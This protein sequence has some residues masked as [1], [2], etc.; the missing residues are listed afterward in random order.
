[1]RRKFNKIGGYIAGA[2]VVLG[3]GAISFFVGMNLAKTKIAAT[4]A[5]YKTL[6][7]PIAV[8][9]MKTLSPI[10]TSSPTPSIPTKQVLNTI[11]APVNKLQIKTQVSLMDGMTLVYVPEGAFQM[12]ITDDEYKKAV[13]LCTADGT[14]QNKCEASIID[15]KPRHTVWLDAFWMD[16]TEITNGMYM[17]CV[18]AGICQPPQKTHSNN[19]LDYYGA[20]QF[21]AYP[22]IYI[23]WNQAN[24]YCLWAGRRLPTEAEWE[25]AARGIDGRL[26]PWG[27]VIDSNKGNFL[28]RDTTRVG[29]FPQGASPYGALDMAGNVWQWVADWYVSS[30]YTESVERNPQGPPT[31][32]CRVIRG[33][34]W[35]ANSLTLRSA[36]RYCMDPAQAE[37]VIGFRCAVGESH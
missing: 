23:D 1:M 14:N 3:I 22:V 31:G 5:V 19:Q 37:G 28:G 16:Q 20:K 21:E 33:G 30:Y 7:S 36:N 34:S 2:V 32:G 12:G 29:I 6:F 13:Q 35:N 8:T 25:K 17:K 18:D 11:L 4:A 27:E 9:P 15:E 24:K 26:Y 10:V